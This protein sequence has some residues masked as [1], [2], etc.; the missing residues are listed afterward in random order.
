MHSRN[1]IQIKIIRMPLSFIKGS[2]TMDIISLIKKVIEK[3]NAKPILNPSFGEVLSDIV[4][5][6]MDM[7]MAIDE[8]TKLKI[9]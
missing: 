2:E 9:S 1:D 4:M 7:T 3:K 8:R 5:K 6:D